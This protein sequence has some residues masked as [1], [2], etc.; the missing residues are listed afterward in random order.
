MGSRRWL[1]GGGFAVAASGGVA[2]YVVFQVNLLTSELGALCSLLAY[3]C[4][5][6]VM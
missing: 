3:T 1:R 6:S 4:R 2:F 5:S